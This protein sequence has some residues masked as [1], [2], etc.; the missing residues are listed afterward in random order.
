MNLKLSKI[1]KSSKLK[2]RNRAPH[3]LLTQNPYR[4]IQYT[5]SFYSRFYTNSIQPLRK[6]YTERNRGYYLKRNEEFF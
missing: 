4:N 1:F 5:N 6:N 3:L 2:K